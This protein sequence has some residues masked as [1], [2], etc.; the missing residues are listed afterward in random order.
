MKRRE[1]LGSMAVLAAAPAPAAVAPN[2]ERTLAAPAVAPPPEIVSPH[3]VLA[4]LVAALPH[5]TWALV[6]PSARID[7]VLYSAGTTQNM[8]IFGGSTFYDPVG[9]RI[10][11][12][13]G[14]HGQPSQLV[15]YDLSTHSWSIL[16][17]PCI[18]THAYQ[19][20]AVDPA[21]GSIYA[22]LLGRNETAGIYRWTGAT[23]ERLCLM[24][25][26]VVNLVA[27]ALAWWTGRLTWYEGAGGRIFLLDVRSLTWSLGATSRAQP[28]AYHNVSVPTAAG[29]VFGGGNNFNDNWPNDRQLWRLDAD[30]NLT[31]MPDAPFRVGIYSGMSLC[32]DG[33]GRVNLLGF[34]QFWRLDP[35]GNGTLHR[36]QD[37][38]PD[39]VK[40]APAGSLMSCAIDELGCAV[41]IQWDRARTPKASMHVFK[42]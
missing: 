26:S 37:P 31:G 41:Y 42:T 9:K 19:H 25:V 23:F 38:P 7:E 4:E 10:P 27:T 18:G 35:S 20:L 15:Q 1:F 11:L 6:P 30:R 12:L 16:E 28:G 36:L 24:P 14:D 33:N 34:G 39:L 32:G 3:G 2:I 13:G 21:T 22:V 29:L 40:P 8:L 5:E 17:R